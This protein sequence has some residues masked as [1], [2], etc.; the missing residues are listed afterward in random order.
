MVRLLDALGVTGLDAD[1]F[2]DAYLGRHAAHW[3]WRDGARDA[4]LAAADHR[5]VGLLTNGFSAQQRAKLARFP[6]LAERA[7][8]V[9]IS[10]EIGVAKPARAVFEHARAEASRATGEALAPGDVVLVGDSLASDVQGAIGAG[11]RAVWLGGDAATA[12][13]GVACVADCAGLASVLTP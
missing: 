8:V 10:D 12:P 11:W 13:E 2:S 4:F 7:T 1:T 6:E 5:P 9:V 3:T